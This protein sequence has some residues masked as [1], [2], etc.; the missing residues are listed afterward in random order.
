MILEFREASGLVLLEADDFKNFKLRLVGGPNLVGLLPEGVTLLDSGNALI[1]CD[2]IPSLATA[3]KSTAWRSG[4]EKMIAAAAKF[5][6]IDE[7]SNAI[8]SHVVWM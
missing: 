8:R 3:P 4:F 5:G 2:L 6:W 1:A 7:A